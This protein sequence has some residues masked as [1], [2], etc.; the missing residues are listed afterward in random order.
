MLPMVSSEELA[1]ELIARID[2]LILTG[3]ED[4]DP[5]YYGEETFNETVE[6]NAPRDTSD[7]LLVKAALKRGIPV[8]AICR[9][10]QLTNVA[11]GGSLYQDLPAQVGD[12]LSHRQTEP[13][14]IGTHW[15]YIEKDTELHRLIGVDSIQVNS[16]HHQAVKQPAPCVKVSARSG[17]GI[18]EAYEAEGLLGLQ[19]HPEC[20]V[21]KGDD[22]FLPIF[23]AFV[24]K[25]AHSTE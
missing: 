2:G 14:N 11:L 9:G 10:E 5:A 13:T 1:D 23:Q 25:A 17:D 6:I 3:G 18:V 16:F 22:T 20:F 19:F 7:M 24:T 12:S 8:L 15:I 4:I 21:S